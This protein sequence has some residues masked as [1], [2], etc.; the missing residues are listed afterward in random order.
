[1]ARQR[2]QQIPVVEPETDEWVDP[3]ERQAKAA[4]RVAEEARKIAQDN[5]EVA[6]RTAGATAIDRA[7]ANHDDWLSV[8]ATKNRLAERFFL[9]QAQ[10]TDFNASSEVSA[11]HKEEQ[12]A[13]AGR[14]EA[15]ANTKATQAAATLSATHTPSPP[16][17]PKTEDRPAWGTPERADYDDNIEREILAEFRG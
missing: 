7:M 1:M 13:L 12:S 8:E 15:W 11:L 5:A 3:A 10:G 17:A 2:M 4:L 14:K 9:A 6:R 16:T